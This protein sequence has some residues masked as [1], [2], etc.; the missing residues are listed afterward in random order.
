[1]K[2]FSFREEYRRS[3]E[4]RGLSS[5]TVSIKLRSVELFSRF[6]E[7]MGKEDLREVN[8]K[9]LS[10]FA[11]YL[12]EDNL[13]LETRRNYLYALKGFLFWLYKEDFL[14]KPVDEL[15]PLI[16]PVKKEKVIFTLE[17]MGLFLDSIEGL[18]L[19]RALFELLYSSA[20]RR[21]EA[22]NLRW[23]DVS[24]GARKLWVKQGKGQR[25]RCVPLSRIA[26]LFLKAWQRESG[27]KK[28]D[29]VFPGFYSR[30]KPLSATALRRR[31]L[32]HLE[33][34][35]IEKKGLTIHSIRHSA[36]TH[37]L[38]AGADV[39]YVSELLGHD[40]MDTTV[41]YT[42][43]TEE[44]QKKAY[45]MY[46]PRENAYYRDLDESYGERLEELRK[47]LRD[48]EIINNR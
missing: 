25:D 10:T 36:A 14:L 39:R 7:E 2:G 22:L 48:R 41:L 15:V 17:E 12:E 8:Q 35:G 31:F 24:L 16:K 3:L 19:D 33:A 5:K 26:C 6:L 9:D 40:N 27:L 43:P 1:M 18:S 21:N 45:R 28:G 37:L 29:Y 23:E 46:H 42:H 4:G 44:N 32:K 11:E 13:A 30:E 20:L 38:E 47:R 34:A